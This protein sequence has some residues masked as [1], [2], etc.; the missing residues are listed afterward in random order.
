MR[1][2][3]LNERNIVID[4]FERLVH[5]IVKQIIRCQIPVGNLSCDRNLE[6]II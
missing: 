1:T 4:S 2:L 6:L 5:I 3:K